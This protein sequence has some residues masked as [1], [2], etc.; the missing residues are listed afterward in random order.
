MS[1][2]DDIKILR[3]FNLGRNT[4]DTSYSLSVDLCQVLF[5]RVIGGIL[6]NGDF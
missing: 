1:L 2:T 6:C 3:I 4:G 5:G